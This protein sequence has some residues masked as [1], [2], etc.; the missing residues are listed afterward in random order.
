VIERR[1]ATHG[2]IDTDV[3]SWLLDP[4]PF[5]HTETADLDVIQTSERL[6]TGSAELRN[7]ANRAAHPIS[8]RIH[9]ADRRV[10]ATAVVLGLELVAVD[11]TFRAPPRS[12]H[13]PHP[14][15]LTRTAV[16]THAHVDGASMHPTVSRNPIPRGDNPGSARPVPPV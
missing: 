10:A 14:P 7:A 5:P 3:V 12:R 8:Q 6:I 13:P 16:R 2:V 11:G 15:L 4:R 1:R 9:E